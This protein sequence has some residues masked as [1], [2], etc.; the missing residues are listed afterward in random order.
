M[1]V[2]KYH[3]I[4]KGIGL[5]LDYYQNFKMKCS[6]D[7]ATMQKVHWKIENFLVSCWR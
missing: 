5:E 3:R 6:E 4:K 1:S 2:K 7:V